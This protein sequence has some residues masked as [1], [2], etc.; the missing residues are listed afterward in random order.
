MPNYDESLV[1][2]YDLPPIL[3][4]SSLQST[5]FRTTWSL[6][7]QELLDTFA[8][9][10]YGI[11]PNRPFQL[12]CELFESGPS[13]AGRALRRQYHVHLKTDAGQHT[14]DLLVFTP[15]AASAP[16]PTFLGLNFFG[17]HT[18]SS[19]PEIAI[20]QAWC[21]PS[22]EMVENNR[23]TEAGRGKASSR[24]PVEMIVDAGFGVATAYC[25]E[26][27]PDFDD[28]FENGVHSLFP[29]N[30]PSPEHPDRWGTISAW[31][32]GLSRLLDC[33]SQSV[34]EVDGGRVV[35]VGH[36]RLGK[37]SLW[38]G[39]TDTRFAAAISNDSGCGGAAL[40]R[41][42][43]GET[44][45]RINTSFPHWFCGNFKKYNRQESNLPIDQ[46][47]LLA[48]LAP[49]PVYVASASKDLW[50][51]P[52]GEFL[53]AQL[54][55]EVYQ[56]FGRK[57]LSLEVFPSPASAEV[58]WVSYHLRDGQHD[59]NEWDWKH[60]IEFLSQL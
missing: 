36:S 6:R 25:G 17:N 10:M 34:P 30:R 37:T 45:E 46:H 47:Q 40:S 28:G 22:P 24:W 52:R 11:Q 8:S 39:A 57:P 7:R 29:E 44:V 50:A 54:V 42:A 3:D 41:R 4:R 20:T 18:V 1:P 38:A 53:S 55:G 13:L 15:A 21:R 32:W 26:I 48:L 27:D 9:Q 16:V 43:F 14:I 58:G 60:Y 59:I 12:Q 33:L 5:D 31:A 51:D 56:K 23:A 2:A 49:R 35:V 19:D